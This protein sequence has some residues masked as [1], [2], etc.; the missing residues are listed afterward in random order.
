MPHFSC[1]T[2]L[3]LASLSCTQPRTAEPPAPRVVDFVPGIRIDY[4]VPQVEVDAEVIL[5][6]GQL[7]L[8]A[9]SKAPVPKEHETILLL[10][11]P[12]ESIYQALGLIGLTPGR[13]PRYDVDTNTLHAATGD[14]VD[15]LVRYESQGRTVEVSACDWMLDLHER[16]PMKRTPWVFAGS[17]R[18]PDGAF[19][20]NGEGTIVTV[21]DFDS[22][23]LA[24]PDLHSSSDSELWL[25]A[26]SAAIP[27]EGT[28]VTL[29]LRPAASSP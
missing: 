16:R 8:F 14:P 15:V 7:E 27:P 12:A 17:R 26:N 3:L 20:A 21:V 13:P 22:S 24:L 25:V 1:T 29:L 6:Q 18:T 23:V 28:E 11:G 9:Y 4:R 19:A 5:R 10:D 2:L